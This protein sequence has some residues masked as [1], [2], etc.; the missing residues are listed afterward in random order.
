MR[1]A[2]GIVSVVRATAAAADVDAVCIAV[3]I[4]VNIVRLSA[5]ATDV[6]AVATED[7]SAMLDLCVHIFGGVYRR[8]YTERPLGTTH[9]QP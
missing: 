3:S 8:I 1:S 9:N 7:S 2:S 5:A 4:A 6:D